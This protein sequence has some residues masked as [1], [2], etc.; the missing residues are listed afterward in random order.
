[1]KRIVIG[2]SLVAVVAAACSPAGGSTSGGKVVVVTTVSPITD[3]AKNVAGN[4]A[5]VQGI[6]PEGVD[7]HTFE[8]SP[9]SA[10]LLAKADLIFLNG[11]HLEDPTLKLAQAD[12]KDG[13]KIFILGEHTITAAQYIYDFSFPRSGGKPNPHLWMDVANAI[14][15]AT[16]I[17]DELIPDDPKNA[18]T[19]RA[20]TTVYLALLHRLN[21]AVQTAINTIPPKNR[22][23]LTYHDSFAYFAH[24]YGM[25]VIGAI[26]PA[27]FAEPSAKEVAALI[28]QIKSQHVPAIFGSEVFPSPVLAQIAQE[29]G[30]K[31]EDTLRDDDLPGDVGGPMHS[32]LGLMVY[33]VRTMV[34]DLGGNP[35]ALDGIPTHS[36]YD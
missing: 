11:L 25:T 14:T 10:K 26:H 16:L 2:L 27:D 22:V 36:Q 3:I 24:H 5:T 23:L 31:F 28:D 1:M 35:S 21:D 15:Y 29:T 12:H 19:H 8:P 34:K 13:A 20:N 17:R 30:V 9:Q 4:A 32:Y 18:V 6:I 7:S 33:D